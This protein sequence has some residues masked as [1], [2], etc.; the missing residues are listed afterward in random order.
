MGH[1]IQQHFG[2]GSNLGAASAT[3]RKRG[4]GNGRRAVAVAGTS[5]EPLLVLNGD[6]VTQVDIGRMLAFH[7]ASGCV[8]TMGVR[9]YSHQVPFGCV[10]I[11]GPRIT[12]FEEKPVLERRINTGVYLLSLRFWRVFP[13]DFIRSLSVR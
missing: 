9:T 3:S 12:G 1:V 11:D 7:A 13:P 5:R 6:L 10:Q 2:D 4:I 8:A